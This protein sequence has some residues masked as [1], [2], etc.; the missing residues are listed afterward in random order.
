MGMKYWRVVCRYGHVGLRREVAVAR[1]LVT[2]CGSSILDVYSLAADMPGVK[3]HGV[4]QIQP[5]NQEAYELGK[6]EE[7]SNFYLQKLKNFKSKGI[8]ERLYA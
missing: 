7:D 2:D 1:F 8:E 6:K 3:S 4:I 5:I